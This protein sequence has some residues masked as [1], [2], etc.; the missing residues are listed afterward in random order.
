MLH[1][2]VHAG[3]IIKNC[4][5]YASSIAYILTYGVRIITNDE[6]QVNAARTVNEN[7]VHAAQPGAW[8]VDS[9]PMMKML[10]AFLAPFKKKA[11][12]F[13]KYETELHLS[14][15]R[16]ALGREGYNWCKG[17]VNAKDARDMSEEELAW[18]L[19]VLADAAIETSNIFLQ[20]FIL[21]CVAHPEFTTTA[22]EEIDAV[23][24]QHEPRMP[25]FFRSRKLSLCLCYCRGGFLLASH[26]A[27]WSCARDSEG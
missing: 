8:L 20:I 11:E 6:W 2:F 12:S 4:E 9:F 21:A 3:E 27:C 1:N 17:F 5:I 7:F 13:W 22:R 15:L 16:Q 23:V 24:A 26:T 14:N 18:N 10:P 19:G 25:E